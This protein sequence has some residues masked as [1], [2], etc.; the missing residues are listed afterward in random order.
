VTMIR[1]II[2][3]SWKNNS[4]SMELELL[5]WNDNLIHV[6]ITVVEY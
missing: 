1:M 2:E 3:W 5:S 6:G 4:C